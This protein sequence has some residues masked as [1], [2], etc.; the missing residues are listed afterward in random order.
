MPNRTGEPRPIG[1]DVTARH[2]LIR[3][4]ATPPTV[5]RPVSA[6]L[7]DN[8]EPVL[9]PGRLQGFIVVVEERV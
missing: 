6:N 1:P 9:L 4:T 3:R 2:R 7:S 8:D 5:A